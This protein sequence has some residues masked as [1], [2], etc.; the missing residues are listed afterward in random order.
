[1]V[2]TIAITGQTTALTGDTVTAFGSGFY[3]IGRSPVTL[4]IRGPVAAASVPVGSDG[5]FTVT[6]TIDDIPSR[7][8]VTAQKAADGSTLT[9]SAPLVVALE[10]E[11][12]TEP[13]N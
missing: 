3:S 12:P 9:D 6:F 5:K 1:L 10:N 8:I 11:I 4:M 2:G 7:Y 13:I